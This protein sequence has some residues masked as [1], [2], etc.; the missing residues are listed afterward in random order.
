MPDGLHGRS[1]QPILSGQ[2]AADWR[3]DY[4]VENITHIS[5]IEQRS[6]QDR[7]WKLIASANGAHELYDLEADPEEEL[8]VFLTPDPTA[9]SNASSTIRTMHR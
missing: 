3:D 9:A 6:V 8:D 2:D 1:L 5:K 7:A 4:Y